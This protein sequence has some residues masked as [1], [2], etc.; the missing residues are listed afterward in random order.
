V[1][2]SRGYPLPMVEKEPCTSGRDPD[3]RGR[4][5]ATHPARNPWPEANLERDACGQTVTRASLTGMSASQEC[6]PKADSGL[7]SRQRYRGYC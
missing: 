2:A 5:A 7:A 4:D 3:G 1:K 6:A